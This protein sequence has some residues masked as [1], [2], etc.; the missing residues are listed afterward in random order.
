MDNLKLEKA[1]YK[2]KDKE[3]ELKV[4]YDSKEIYL[5]VKD[6]SKLYD[7]DESSIRKKIK[8]LTREINGE[9]DPVHANFAYTEV[10]I[11]TTGS[12]GKT[13][14]TNIYNSSVIFALGLEFKSE[15]TI[16]LKEFMSNLFK[17]NE[18]TIN[19]NLSLNKANNY[20]IVRYDNGE[21]IIDVNVSVK[22]DTVWLTQN[23]IAK[24]FDSNKQLISYHIN[25]I[26]SEKELDEWATVKENLTVQNEGD[27]SI[28]RSIKL[29]NLDMIISIG[30]RVN[31]KRGIEFRKWATTIL[32]SYL[33]NA[34]GKKDF[35]IIF[36]D[37][38]KPKYILDS[39]NYKL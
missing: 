35:E 5:T 4:N 19:D 37:K 13:Y 9:T 34:L 32:K 38:L 39:I 26:L 1:I 7:K 27:R 22:E 3:V 17:E 15:I 29:Y 25:N 6:M 11:N 8:P 2:Y 24:L 10:K 33:L 14:K 12:D 31:S 20:G 23:D 21:I 30:Y 36:L 28:T 16:D 18:Y